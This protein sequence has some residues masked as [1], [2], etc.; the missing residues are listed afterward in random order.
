M[1]FLKHPLFKNTFI[2]VITDSINKVIPFI[3]LSV[4]TRF[5]SPEDYGRVA[6]Y[7]VLSGILSIF[8]GLSTHGAVSVNFFKLERDNL[9][10]YIANIIIIL[11]IS[12][13]IVT[14]LLCT[15]SGVLSKYLH[16]PRGWI[17]IVPFVS[18][19]QFLTLLNMTLW[20]SEQRPMPFGIYQI[21]QTLAYTILVLFFVVALKMR[22][23]G[24][25]LANLISIVLFAFFSLFIIIKRGY[26]KF[27]FHLEYVKDALF[28]GVPLI[29]HQLANWIKNGVDRIFL[30]TMVG[31]AATGIY[32]VGYQFG[33]IIG[34]LGNA[35]NKAW[36]PFLFEKMKSIDQHQ[37]VRLVK[38]SYLCFIAIIAATMIFSLVA[39]WFM[40][41]FL[42]DRFTN[43]SKFVVWIAF[44][45]A[46]DTMYYVVTNQ[47]FFVKAT[48][49][50]A[51]VTFVSSLIHIIL[52]YTLI[53][54]NGSIGSAQAITISFFITFLSVWILSAKVYPMPWLS[55]LRSQ[56]PQ[57][58]KG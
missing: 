28:F 49:L 22:W 46:F 7:F 19:S 12:T 23:Q 55:F 35:F 16:I 45:Y 25:L 41:F 36:A 27:E 54:L 15:L 6:N 52:S 8:V 5:L 4:L 47:I 29:P 48:H 38:F 17:L 21:L 57:A 3:M 32:S 44:G 53:K 33:M 34:L 42:G 11:V 1:K 30:T 18:F 50:L 10:K 26:F 58:Q 51:I 37:K 40:G 20:Q 24:Q 39:P 2:Y 13:I 31:V 56:A 43:A 9:R 14:L